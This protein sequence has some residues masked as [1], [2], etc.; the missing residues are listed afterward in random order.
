ME[1]L[2]LLCYA[3][4]S[5][6]IFKIFRIPLN[7]WTVPTAVLGGV[8][9]IGALILGMNYNFPYTDIGKQV[10][11]TVPVVSQTRGR[12]MSVPVQPNQMLHKGD[13]LFTLD[14]TPF[15]AQVDDLTAQVKAASQDAL[16]LNAALNSAQADL[17]KAIAL[18]DRAQRE[19]ARFQAGHD[20]GA[21]SDQMVDTRRQ[22]WKADEAAV[23]A[24]Q[25]SVVQAH[26]NLNSVVNGENTKVA[27][28]LAQLRAAEF[29]LENTVV[30]A[31]SDGYVSTVGLRPGTMSTA[32][33]LKPVMTFVP[34]GE[35]DKREF[36]A[37]FRQNSLQRLEKGE[38]AE[39]LFPA[40]PGTVFHAE[41][42]E[43]LPAIGESQF[44]GQGTL[45]TTRDLDT[46]GRALVVFRVTDT[47]LQNYH[48]PQGTDVEAAVYSGHLEHLSLIRKILIRMKSWENY[49]Y[50][51]H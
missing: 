24:A 35:A 38:Q 1:T 51:D 16:S 29:K 10:F 12:V 30:R 2:L 17:Q 15:Q 44:Q 26:N 40:V 37:A 46:R 7:K 9:L 36:V 19:Y 28:L 5:I 22:S 43:V 31:P 11:R 50:L 8:V 4:L 33:G 45:L 34:T 21:F 47:R 25:A 3:A 32:L 13:V 48:L 39:L 14:P 41:V 42:T 6:A 18:R 49:L 23:A 27:S 20:K